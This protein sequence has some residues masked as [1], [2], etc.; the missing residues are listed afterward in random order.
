MVKVGTDKPFFRQTT[1]LTQGTGPVQTQTSVEVQTITIGTVLSLTPQISEDGWITMDISPVITRLVDT[2]SATTGG[3]V[4]TAPEVDIKQTSSLVRI[5]EGT[6]VVIGGLIQ[7][8]RYKT[9]RKV[10]FIGD[11]PVLGYMFRGVFEKK[12]RTE[13]VIFITPTIVH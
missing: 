4:T 6:T 13:L 3:S 10:P 9:T 2:V 7:N 5:R 8:E 12:R 1:I 11:I